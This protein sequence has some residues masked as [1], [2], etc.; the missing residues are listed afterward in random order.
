MTF[1]S[2]KRFPQLSLGVVRSPKRDLPPGTPKQ[3]FVGC[4]D[5][6]EKSLRI[7]KTGLSNTRFDLKSQRSKS[8][9]LRFV[10]G[11]WIAQGV[12]NSVVFFL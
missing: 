6:L 2:A 3:E 12:K 10:Y 5:K 8:L 4:G 9:I 1:V 11:F 7:F